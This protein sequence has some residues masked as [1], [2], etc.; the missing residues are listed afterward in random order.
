MIKLIFVELELE[1]QRSAI[2]LRFDL[3]LVCDEFKIVVLRLDAVKADAARQ[4]IF[5]VAHHSVKLLDRHAVA[6]EVERHVHVLDGRFNRFEFRR[7][8][9]H[10]NFPVDER[11]SRR[12]GDA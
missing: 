1:R 2:E 7:P 4:L 9:E 8:L 12:A 6:G 3:K 5:A 10:G 11:M